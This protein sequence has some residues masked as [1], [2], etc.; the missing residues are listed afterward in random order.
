M[1]PTPTKAPGHYRWSICALLFFSVTINYV[2]RQI[3]GILKQPL[4]AELG[5]SEMD[6]ARIV[7]WFQTAYAFGYLFGGRMMDFL[8]VKR[9]FPIIVFAWS[10]ACA[11]HGAVRSVVGFQWAR[12]A[13]GLAEGG[14]FPGAIKTVAE[15]FPT[16]ERAMATG[17]FNAGTNIGA[18]ICPLLVPWA[19][20]TFGWQMTFYVTGA[21]GVFWI[22]A[23]ALLYEAPEKHRMLSPAEYAYI[24]EGRDKATD[25]AAADRKAAA[26]KSSAKQMLL[27]VPLLLWETLVLWW[28]LLRHRAVW[29]YLIAGVLA[30]PIWG[31]YMFFLP[32]FLQKRFHL[33]LIEVGQWTALFYLVAS[34]GGVAGGW[35]FSKLL[36]SGLSLNA[37]RKLS[38]LACA[39]C[40]VP[41]FYA[42]YA[43]SIWLCVFIVGLAGSAHQGWSANLFSFV[44]DTMPKA[45]VGAVVGMGGFMAF[46][47]GGKL[48]KITGYLLETTG[49]YVSIFAWASSMYLFSLLAV[50]LLVPKIGH[51]DPNA[52]ETKA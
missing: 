20:T 30:G 34:F 18:I 12:A 29:A 39:L 36:T 32:D 15:W 10:L 1:S 51:V 22:I 14:N 9:G 48:A 8:G 21:L 38:L 33:S 43:T 40:V 45:T 7:E 26:P 19:A 52:P 50:H 4:S 24:T 37:A 16:K 3:I 41:V 46:Y 23:W 44:S 35:L 25:A 27:A 47:T 5:W 6:Y 28:G 31:F 42:P 2:D 17:I 13:L 49:S 11:L